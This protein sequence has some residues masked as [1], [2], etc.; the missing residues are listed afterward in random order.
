MRLTLLSA[1]LGEQGL[2]VQATAHA[3]SSA[4]LSPVRIDSPRHQA[5]FPPVS[6]VIDLRQMLMLYLMRNVRPAPGSLFRSDRI[7]LM[8]EMHGDWR[9][10]CTALLK[11]GIMGAVPRFAGTSVAALGGRAARKRQIRFQLLRWRDGPERTH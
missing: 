7:T 8:I 1:A 3:K 11:I 4:S 10:K 6:E 9:E 5:A 2:G